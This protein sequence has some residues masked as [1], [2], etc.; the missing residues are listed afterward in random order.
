[1]EETQIEVHHVSSIGWY[2]RQ[3]EASQ[4]E[5][6]GLVHGRTNEQ[7]QTRSCLE[8]PKGVQSESCF[9][10]LNRLKWSLRTS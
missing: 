5:R 2:D 8:P 1:M 4:P 3:F 10:A 9:L 6:H 7:S